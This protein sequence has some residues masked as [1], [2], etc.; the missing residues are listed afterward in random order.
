M[1][2]VA[3][4]RYGEFDQ[5]KFMELPIPEPL[6][7]EVQIEVA[8]AG[9]NPVDW[10]ICLGMVN[11][12]SGDFPI[13]LGWDF[14][15]VVT[16]VGK[17]VRT[18]KE[19]DL[20]FGFAKTTRGSFAEY[21][22]FD[23]EHVVK[24]PSNLKLSQAAAIPLAALTA[25]QALVEIA[26]VQKNEKVLVHGGAGGVGSMAIQ[27]ARYLQASVATT[28]REANH[29]YVR[30]LGADVAIDYTNQE[31]A[32]L[33]KKAAPEGFD[34]IVDCVGGH[35][36]EESYAALK[37]RGRLVSIAELPNEEKT[38]TYDVHAT[39]FNVRPDGPGL[40]KIASLFE[41]GTFIPLEI[42]VVPFFKA[43]NA[44]AKIREG[45]TRGK[46]VLQVKDFSSK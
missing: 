43:K 16:K 37:K 27:I 14:S 8:Y 6:P 17:D 3:I 9:V 18:L 15:G 12:P 1:K 34:V 30:Q 38:K 33:L 40:Q 28:A 26:N 31:S 41:R 23:A 29:L 4:Q 11:M 45:H 13:I 39:H 21:L 22:C 35:V 2:A 25:F 36:L 44:L 24:I 20:V 7:F 5:I 42:E 10:K 19:G 32:Y 46:I